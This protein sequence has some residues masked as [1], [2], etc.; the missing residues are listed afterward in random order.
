MKNSTMNFSKYLIV[1]ILF[2]SCEEQNSKIIN[3]GN[4]KN[5]SVNLDVPLKLSNFKNYGLF[6]DR[7]RKITCNDSIPKI[8]VKVLASGSDG[9]DSN[10]YNYI[11]FP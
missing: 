9:P 10:L 5:E 1:F 4:S 7:I 2:I 8:V 6:V 3:Y 11:A